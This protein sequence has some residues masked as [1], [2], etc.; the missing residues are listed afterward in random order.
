MNF[1]SI[2]QQFGDRLGKVSTIDTVYSDT[3]YFLL[4]FFFILAYH[5]SPVILKMCVAITQNL[6]QSFPFSATFDI[7]PRHEATAMHACV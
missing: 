5:F 3:F 4:R 7:E 1:E 2:V 6:R